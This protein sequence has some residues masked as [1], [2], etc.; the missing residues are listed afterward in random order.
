MY[1]DAG[2]SPADAAFL[3]SA[4]GITNTIGRL[5]LLIYS[6]LT[7]LARFFGGWLSDQPWTHPLYLTLMA[8]TAAVLPSF[9]LPW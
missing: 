9:V 2:V 6:F 8:I 4:A 5:V 1:Q 7:M 3:I